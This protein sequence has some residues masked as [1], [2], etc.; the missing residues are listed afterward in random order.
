MRSL[1][2]EL[3]LEANYGNHMASM[4][5][6]WMERAKQAEQ[7]AGVLILAAGGEIVVHNGHLDDAHDLVIEREE[8]CY[9]L[10]THFRARRRTKAARENS[11]KTASENGGNA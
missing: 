10:A 6:Y 5:R 3:A 8:R 1:A 2:D 11:V 9:D 4:A 7:M